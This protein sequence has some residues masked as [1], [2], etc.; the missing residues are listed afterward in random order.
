MN[1]LFNYARLMILCKSITTYFTIILEL[2][3]RYISYSNIV[4]G[5]LRGVYNSFYSSVFG[6]FICY[7]YVAVF[8]D[9]GWSYVLLIRFYSLTCIFI[10]EVIL[11]LCSQYCSRIKMNSHS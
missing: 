5:M 2:I 11:F 6:S 3:N 7:D 10:Q 9:F 4:V 8:F 1:V